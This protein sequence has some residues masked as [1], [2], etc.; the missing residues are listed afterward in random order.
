MRALRRGY[1]GRPGSVWSRIQDI[2][3]GCNIARQLSEK[4]CYRPLDR[5]LPFE[6]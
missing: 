5:L 2:S 1:Y 4:S 3:E 6:S